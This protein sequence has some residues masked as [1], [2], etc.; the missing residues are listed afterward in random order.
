MRIIR[1]DIQSIRLSEEIEMKIR[2]DT[3][4]ASLGNTPIGRL[5][6]ASRMAFIA[7]GFH[8]IRLRCGK[9]DSP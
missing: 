5:R 9:G 4:H 6:E 7:Y 1:F 3:R 8:P 2:C